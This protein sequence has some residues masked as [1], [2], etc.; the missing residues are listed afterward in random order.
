MSTVSIEKPRPSF[1]P[2]GSFT[3]EEI[4]YHSNHKPV[5]R[6][7]G[8][9]APE[10]QPPRK[11]G[12]MK[13]TVRYMALIR[14]TAGRLQGVHGLRLLLDSHTVIWAVG[15]STAVECRGG[16]KTKKFFRPWARPS[17]PLLISAARSGKSP[18]GRWES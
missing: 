14:C 6:L 12:T 17:E 8:E 2:I 15:R 11:L 4:V 1:R 18:Q 16:Q 3:G 7:I 9:K 10:Q 5:A 13:G